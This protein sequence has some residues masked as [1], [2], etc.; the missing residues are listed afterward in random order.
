MPTRAPADVEEAKADT[1]P[2]IDVVFL[3]IV[4]FVCIDFRVLEAKLPALLPLDRGGSP[5]LVEPQRQLVVRVHVTAP[6]TMVPT[7]AADANG[8]DAATGRPPRHRLEGHRV[9]WEIG[10][11]RFDDL[12]AAR[13]EL[14]RIAADPANHVADRDTGARGPM[15]CVVEAMRGAC[16]EDVARTTDACH[17]AGFPRIHFGG[18]LD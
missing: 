4:F 5:D 1:T 17:A 14:A 7:G 12:G 11:R 3:M 10:P 15:D 16:Y 18:G 8:V 9:A 6:G 2:M 13:A